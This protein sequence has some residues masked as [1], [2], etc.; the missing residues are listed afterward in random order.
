MTDFTKIKEA[1][2]AA[3]AA[4]V[5]TVTAVGAAVGPARA[6]DADPV[7]YADADTGEIGRG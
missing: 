2:V 5:L 3:V 7:T 6:L 1:M 4:L